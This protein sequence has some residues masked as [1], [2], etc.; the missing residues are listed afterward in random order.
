MP[1]I[2]LNNYDLNKVRKTQIPSISEN[3]YF[4]EKVYDFG[5]RERFIF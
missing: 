2:I 1:A 5:Y 4:S 3:L